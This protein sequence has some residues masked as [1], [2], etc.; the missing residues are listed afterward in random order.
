MIRDWPVDV[1]EEELTSRCCRD[2]EGTEDSSVQML[3]RGSTWR[4]SN[5]GREICCH[6]SMKTKCQLATDREMLHSLEPLRKD[7]ILLMKKAHSSAH[8]HTNSRDE[9]QASLVLLISG[10]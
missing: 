8:T 9:G 2:T 5:S 3:E 1:E 6:V 4:S 10:Q 7:F